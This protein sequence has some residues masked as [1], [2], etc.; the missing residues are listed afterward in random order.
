MKE[1]YADRTDEFFRYRKALMIARLF[2][3]A[4]KP[5][6][7]SEELVM[8]LNEVGSALAAGTESKA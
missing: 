5:A 8:T 1:R 2:L 3:K 7:N 6:A 4:L